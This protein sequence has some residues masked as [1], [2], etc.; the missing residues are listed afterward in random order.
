MKESK[1]PFVSMYKGFKN[2]FKE[3]NLVVT[4]SMLDGFATG[5]VIDQKVLVQ[6]AIILTESIT[7]KILA[8]GEI[9]KA[10]TV[11]LAKVS[12]GAKAR[13]V[14]AGGTVEEI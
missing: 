12:E 9:T 5:T 13:I 3:K 6:A 10:L 2:I 8:N 11:K 7:V 1:N 14:E 4:L